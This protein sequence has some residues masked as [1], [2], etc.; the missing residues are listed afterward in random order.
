MTGG[1]TLL[2]GLPA[3][4]LRMVLAS[5]L[6]IAQNAVAISTMDRHRIRGI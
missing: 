2:S 5:Y 4:I 3:T 6:Q 1:V